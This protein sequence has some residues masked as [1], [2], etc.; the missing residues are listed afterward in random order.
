MA[1]SQDW[2][3]FKD[4]TRH[5]RREKGWPGTS[6]SIARVI[7]LRALRRFGCVAVFTLS[8]MVTPEVVLND[9]LQVARLY[10]SR[11]YFDQL[12]AGWLCATFKW[13]ASVPQGAQRLK[14]ALAENRQQLPTT[15]GHAP[16]PD[17]RTGPISNQ[18]RRT[19]NSLRYPFRAKAWCFAGNLDN[20]LGKV[21]NRLDLETLWRT[22]S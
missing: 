14:S 9:S 7:A 8:S 13:Q 6:C 16:F 20:V 2:I 12:V 11:S 19:E 10:V 15:E 4:T 5:T 3:A 22:K 17:Q 21:P 18:I 1:L